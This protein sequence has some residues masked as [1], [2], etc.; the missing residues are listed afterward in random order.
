MLTRLLK[1][2]PKT[3]I[4]FCERCASVCDTVCRS[5]A[6]RAKALDRALDRGARWA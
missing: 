6:A 4:Q 2:G 5:E 3:A 1:R